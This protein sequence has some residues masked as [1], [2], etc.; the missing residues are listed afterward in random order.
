MGYDMYIIAP[1]HSDDHENKNFPLNNC[2]LYKDPWY[3]KKEHSHQIWRCWRNNE[4]NDGT[5]LPT[6]LGLSL[7]Y[8]PYTNNFRHEFNEYIKSNN[9]IEKYAIYEVI[10]Y[11]DW[12]DYW[13]Q[14]NA[15]FYLSM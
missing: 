9:K 15:K 13:K 8:S 3:E 14:K 10:N 4:L 11:L 6:M 12:I 2:D 7:I 5:K 1:H